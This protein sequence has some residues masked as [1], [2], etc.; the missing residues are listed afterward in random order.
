VGR[1]DQ[2]RPELPADVVVVLGVSGLAI[3]L[4]VLGFNLVGDGLRDLLDPK[5]RG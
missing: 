2:P 4:T 3:Y 5:S 1:N